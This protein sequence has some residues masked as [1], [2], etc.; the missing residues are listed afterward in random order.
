MTPYAHVLTPKEG[1][2][3]TFRRMKQ[4]SP[5]HNPIDL[6]NYCFIH[7]TWYIFVLWCFSYTTCCTIFTDFVQCNIANNNDTSNWMNNSNYETK[8]SL[9]QNIF[10]INFWI[11]NSPMWYETNLCSNKLFQNCEFTKFQARR[12]PHPKDQTT[13]QTTHTIIHP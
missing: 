8:C 6:A 12:T 11:N 5:I 13:M 4:N 7:N 3:K 10:Y 9:L 2:A 1:V